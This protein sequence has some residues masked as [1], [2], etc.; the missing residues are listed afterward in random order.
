LW[1][2]FPGAKRGSH[3]G[4]GEFIY[5]N[6]KLLLFII[7][8]RS[9]SIGQVGRIFK[10]DEDGDAHVAYGPVWTFHPDVLHK[11]NK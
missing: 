4:Y 5:N 7:N 10:I 2:S 3:K 9:K 1:V 11:V 6:Y 8:A